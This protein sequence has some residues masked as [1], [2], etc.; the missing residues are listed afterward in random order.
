VKQLSDL[1]FTIL[2]IISKRAP[3][4][5]YAVAKEFFTSPSSHWRGSAGAVYP[6][7]ARLKALGLLRQE[8][9][10]RLGRPATLFSLTD[11]GRTTLRK[12]LTPPLPES[13]ASITFDPIRTRSFFLAAL[14]PAEQRAFLEEAERQLLS[15]VPR[16]EAECDRYRKS[17][18]W[19]SEQSQR[20]TL[21]VTNARVAWIREFLDA[22][23]RRSV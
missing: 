4:T 16:L 22:L 6:A 17:G 2:G 14:S 7:V 8:R 9:A 5:S 10:T 13:A 12:W 15:Q 23:S 3:C 19:F 11:K 21:H 1:E 20:G 18:D